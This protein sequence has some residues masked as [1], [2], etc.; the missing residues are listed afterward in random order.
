MR[1]ALFRPSA[2]VPVAA[3]RNRGADTG[4]GDYT[5]ASATGRGPRTR[6]EEPV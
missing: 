1:G 6:P 3:A 2:W 4:R 5:G